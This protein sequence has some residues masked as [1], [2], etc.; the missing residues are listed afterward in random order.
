MATRK[1][2]KRISKKI[3]P[4]FYKGLSILFTFSFVTFSLIIFQS[5]TINDAIV[6]IKRIFSDGGE[7]FLFPSA[8][9]FMIIGCTIMII[10]DLQEEYNIWQFSLFSNKRWIVRELSYVFLLIY[11]LLAGVFDGGQFIYFSF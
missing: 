1:A 8:A 3:N 6:I 7:L 10:Y 4:G 9:L 5:A 2:R 11:I